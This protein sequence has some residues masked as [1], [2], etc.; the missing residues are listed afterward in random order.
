MTYLYIKVNGKT[1][2][3]HRHVVESI[4]GKPLPVGA[5]IHHWDE[6][7]KNNDS[8]NLA[9]FPDEAYHRLIHQRMRAMEVCGNPNAL[10]CHIC[11]GYGDQEDIRIRKIGVHTKSE[12][13]K[14]TQA[15][16]KGRKRGKYADFY[17]K[18]WGHGQ[19]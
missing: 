3:A 18:A 10:R 9:V 4:L 11:H 2:T 8:S 15:A 1:V 12:H 13:W 7:K 17:A 6:D 16:E 14:C 5:V 19:P